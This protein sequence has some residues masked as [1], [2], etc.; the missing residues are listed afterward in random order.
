MLVS[1]VL[2][3]SSAER[4]FGDPFRAISVPP[5][6]TDFTL[7][8]SGRILVA[9]A[10]PLCRP[11]FRCTLQSQLDRTRVSFKSFHPRQPRDIRSQTPD[12]VLGRIDYTTALDEIV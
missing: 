4:D 11:R 6:L 9:I 8:G 7:A 12:R 1:R 3:A 10:C 2:R 5:L